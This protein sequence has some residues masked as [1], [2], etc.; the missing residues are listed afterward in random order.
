MQKDKIKKEIIYW[1]KL[2]NQ[3]NLV[4]ARSGNISYKLSED[5]ILI[6]SHDC[7]L[8]DLKEEDILL[9]SKEGEILEGEKEITSEK[10]LHLDIYKE[11]EDAKVILHAHPP[12]TVAF[13]HYFDKLDIFSFEARFYLG[14]VKVILQET[15][16]VIDTK[17][18]IE[19]L[20]AVNIVVLKEHGVVSIGR[21][22]REALSLIE[23]LEEQSKINLLIRS[24]F[25]KEEKEFFKDEDNQKEVKTKYK[26]LS[27]EHIKRLVEL[28]NNDRQTQEL[29][30][31]Y[32]L[33]C[34]LAIKNQDSKRTICFYYKK[35]KITKV[36]NNEY[37][38]IL[39][40]GKEEILKKIFNQDLDPFVAATHRKIEIK[41]DL[42]KISMWYQVLARIFTIWK[43][44]PVE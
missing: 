15:P 26:L 34:T 35:G 41:G 39:I 38:E 19:A 31:K 24:G 1:A 8:G 7:Y 29:G 21:D 33:T 2:L 30:E 5:K 36:D 27:S 44:A 11:I 3:K 13:F 18:V 16:T 23:L 42:S 17:P 43:R 28:V 6:T 12:Y 32:D 22:F 20:K 10:K 37:A 25:L 4:S 14:N 40:A 9:I